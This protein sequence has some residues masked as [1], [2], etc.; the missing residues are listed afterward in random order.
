MAGANQSVAARQC[1]AGLLCVGIAV[2]L[3]IAASLGGCGGSSGSSVASSAVATDSTGGGTSTAAACGA[4]SCGPLLLTMTDAR[5][6]FLSYVV[7]ISSLQLETAG[8]AVVET[9]P[10]ATQVDFSQ[11]VDLSE[12]MRAG[13]I[14]AAEY[15]SA[16]LTLDFSKA[17][18]TADD[19]S[20]NAVPLQALDSNGMPLTG[21]VAV[22]IKL[23]SANHL[24]IAPGNSGRLALDFN[25]AA[26]NTVDLTADAVTVSPTLVASVVPADT[27]PMRVR[28]QLVSASTG[29]DDFVVN[30]QPFV[31]QGKSTGQITVSVTPA[32]T[33]LINGTGMVGA[34]G[35]AALAA[36]PANTL[37]AAYGA[38]QSDGQTFT[39]QSVVA[40][41]SFASP[42]KDH[43]GG[44]VVARDASGL[45]LRRATQWNRDGGF[46]FEAH[47]VT[48]TLGSSTQ[49]AGQ[50]VGAALS[51]ADISV[52]Q[53]VDAFGTFT[54]TPQSMM[55][56][57][58]NISAPV[59]P[60]MP[61][62]SEHSGT[63]DASNGL[64]TLTETAAWGVVTAM[65]AGSVTL[66]LQS[67]DGLP[68]SAFNFAGTGSAGIDAT[69]KAYIV[70]TGTLD[71]SALN[72]GAPARVIGFV[73]PWGAAPP[74]F[75]AHTLINYSAVPAVLLVDWTHPGSPTAFTG[76]TATVTSLQLDLA[77]IGAQ[78]VVQLGPQTID[79][80]RLGNAP[81]LLPAAG[82][83]DVFTIGHQGKG[84]PTVENFNTFAAFVT[85]L[86]TE[87]SGTTGVVDVTATG[88]FDSTT[89]TLTASRIA[90]LLNE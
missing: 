61:V 83:T 47:D 46:E 75:T 41:S 2:S 15:V 90:V 20:G 58:H 63:L 8:G 9:L 48:V 31:M 60:G 16:T 87:L 14:P 37:L 86:S 17:G 32:T 69:A 52:G 59:G 10:V 64:V 4:A 5:G 68:A 72:V 29:K 78:H 42:G 30:V 49:V 24:R 80:T 67:I 45:T 7:T 70:S 13:Q 71:Q 51:T 26:S 76:L 89:A 56:D 43:V 23:D 18:I 27:R 55:V 12:I 40:G 62:G 36:L 28:G 54:A 33:Y 22:S 84:K 79:L 34:V 82:T 65:K 21:S 44:T 39:A 53:H 88:Q 6:D 25:L 1:R 50:G 66:N 3:G 35:L 11:L 38:L 74:D 85:A 57:P 73:T 81:T 19:G 77:Q